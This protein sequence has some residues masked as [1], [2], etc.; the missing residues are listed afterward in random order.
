MQGVIVFHLAFGLPFAV[1]LLRNFMGNM[2]RA[3]LEA[4]QMDGAGHFLIFSKILLPLT[5]PAI[6]SLSIFQFLWVWNDMMIALIC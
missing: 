3:L 5:M 6:A 2:P 4:A 1:F